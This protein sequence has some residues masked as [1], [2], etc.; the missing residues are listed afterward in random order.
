[1]LSFIFG[2]RAGRT[3]QSKTAAGWP[4][5]RI[6]LQTALDVLQ[7]RTKLYGLLRGFQMLFRCFSDVFRCFAKQDRP[8]DVYTDHRALAE[9][10]EE[11]SRSQGT[12]TNPGGD[13]CGG[14]SWS[15]TKSHDSRQ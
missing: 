11:S 5:S 1:M 14:V 6:A 2:C 10:L 7:S 13:V 3:R 15:P 4:K 8:S 12:T 9:D